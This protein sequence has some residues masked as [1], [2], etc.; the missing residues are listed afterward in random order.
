[1]RSSKLGFTITLIIL[2]LA[3]ACSKP[4][5]QSS[6]SAA[7]SPAPAGTP[8]AG[9][10]AGGRAPGVVA[11]GAAAP[12]AAA[13]QVPAGTTVTVRL[14]NA[15]GSKISKSGDEFT[16]TVAEPLE[17]GGKV[18]AAPGAAAQGVV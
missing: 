6:S 3:L 11:P 8:A 5:D 1:M 12:A 2:A 4:A 18:V 7:P 9:G 13:I 10:S 14:G 16:A 17:V 15:V